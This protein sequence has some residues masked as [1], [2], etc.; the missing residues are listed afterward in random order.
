MA[1]QL[2]LAKPAFQWYI[3]LKSMTILNFFQPAH[4][5]RLWGGGVIKKGNHGEVH[6]KMPGLYQVPKL[7]N[8]N[9]EKKLTNGCTVGQ[10]DFYYPLVADKSRT[11]QTMS[12]ITRLSIT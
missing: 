12:N 6:A 9:L 2:K 7:N 3:T 1:V 5:P 8:L 11:N 4:P 10:S